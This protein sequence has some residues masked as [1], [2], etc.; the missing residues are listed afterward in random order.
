M[1]KRKLHNLTYFQ[2]DWTGLPMRATNCHM[3][4]WNEANKL[5]KHGSYCNWE[6]V[7][8]H[9]WESHGESEHYERINTYVTGLVGTPVTR[10]PH[11]GQLAWFNRDNNERAIDSPSTF[12]ALC[13][14]TEAPVVGVR[15]TSDGAVHE[16]FCTEALSVHLTRP[17]NLQGPLHTPQV[18]Q[19]VRRKC[20][21]RDLNVYYWP[22]KNGLPLNQTASTLFKMQIY[23]DV[24][25]VQQ[26]K[27]MC[28]WPRERYINYTLQMFNEQYRPKRRKDA[29]NVFSEEEY[30]KVKVEMNQA[31][32]AVEEAASSLAC[33]PLELAKASVLPSPSGKA[34]ASLARARVVEATA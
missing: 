12:H 5:I 1:G 19:T 15:M 33:A 28:A 30:A 9:A 22:S 8:A 24:L 31:L 7:L 10:A 21:D 13:S 16:V 23:G 20:K 27:E 17:F 4:T 6:S 29:P 2:C 18:F 14:K 26:S 25:M 3:P 32:Q 34:L 11:Y